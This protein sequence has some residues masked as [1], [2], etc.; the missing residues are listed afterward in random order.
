M[1]KKKVSLTKEERKDKALQLLEK[2]YTKYPEWKQ[3]SYKLSEP[4]YPSKLVN[5][6]IA[7]KQVAQVPI[8]DISKSVLCGSL[9]GDSSIAIN[10]GYA[11]ARYQNRHSTRQM[12][13]FVWKNLVVLKKFN[14]ESGVSYQ[15]PDGYQEN[16]TPMPGEILGKVKV[17]S[18]AKPE[19]TALHNIIVEGGK[20]K[21][22][23]SWLNHMN[24]Y[25]LMT[26]WLDDGSLM[27]N[28]Q[29]VICLNSTPQSEQTILRG[30][31]LKVWGIESSSQQGAVMKNG[32]VSYRIT[33][34]N[35]E[36]LLKLLRLIA[37]LIPVREMLYKIYFVPENNPSLLQR[38]KTEVLE[39]VR[40]EFVDDVKEFYDKL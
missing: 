38:W 33:I 28:R 3:Q 21:I 1:S 11:N 8:D 10:K 16:V 29:G 13:W 27:H 35:M 31:L 9:V 14:N 2:T 20:T 7:E 6:H 32:Q 23:R 5:V 40:P 34:D 12:S 24:S 39:L 22:K 4:T 37:P 17:A 25:F 18:K 19:L 26:V 15:E 36:S 30:Y